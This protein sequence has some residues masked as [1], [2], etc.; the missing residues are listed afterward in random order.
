MRSRWFGALVVSVLAGC[1]ASPVTD[2]G[3]DVPADLAAD[4]V[5]PDAPVDVSVDRGAPVADRGV[6]ASVDVGATD[7]G[8]LDA[9]A[10]DAGAVD[11]GATDAG[12]VDADVEARVD[13]VVVLDAAPDLPAVDVGDAGDAGPDVSALASACGMDGGL[14]VTRTVGADGGVVSVGAVT[15]TI[16]AGALATDT[17]ITIAESPNPIPE[18]FEPASSMY[19][20]RPAGLSYAMPVTVAIDGHPTSGTRLAEMDILWA[21]TIDYGRTYGN[22][23]SFGNQ[24]TSVDR[25]VSTTT[26]HSW[27]FVGIWRGRS[28]GDGGAC[29]PVDA[30]PPCGARF[31]ACAG[32]CVDLRNSEE[33]CGACGSACPTGASCV[34]S[35]CVQP[36]A[37]PT[38]RCGAACVNVQ[39]D[40]N[41]CGGC[42]R[43]CNPDGGI[44]V[45][46]AGVC[47][48]PG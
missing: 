1:D 8:L 37:A 13:V 42:D 14:A 23:V 32:R 24:A 10:T 26:S 5:A 27:G 11:V 40:A 6:E 34:A 12:L 39:T 45:C 28:C 31:T 21:P 3:T 22:F 46:R 7:A 9:G 17:V 35:T 18:G 29:V 43:P 47:R 20:F 15:L 44:R 25:A 19:C 16:P 41:H 36:C 4:A 38:V 48:P 33:H 30:P 2:A